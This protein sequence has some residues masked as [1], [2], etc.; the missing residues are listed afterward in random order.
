MVR[1][2][3]ASGICAKRNPGG[4]FQ[5]NFVAG[6]SEIV[7][8]RKPGRERADETIL[9][10]H[11]GLSLSDIALGAAMLDKAKRRL[12]S[13]VKSSAPNLI[14]DVANDD[15]RGLSAGCRPAQNGKGVRAEAQA[16]RQAE[17]PC[18]TTCLD[19][20]H[21]CNHP[22]GRNGPEP[23]PVASMAAAISAKSRPVKS[24]LAASSQPST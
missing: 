2:G 8:G 12:G 10:W 11:R 6:Y 15:L 22:R 20:H 13:S 21:Q 19:H 24:R 5:E 18:L 9:L 14:G 4:V 17:E 3:V 23:A 7:A 16:P 1:E